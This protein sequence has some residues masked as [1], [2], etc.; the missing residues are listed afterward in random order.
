MRRIPYTLS[1]V[2]APTLN[3]P[4][5]PDDDGSA[6]PGLRDALAEYAAGR[7]SEHTVLQQLSEA[8]L[9]LPVVPLPPEQRHQAGCRSHHDHDHD[10][11]HHD[12]G[13]AMATPTLIGE[14]GRRGYLGFT[15]LE[16]LQ[17]W[18]ADARP[19][20]VRAQD[21][22]RS[23]LEHNAHALVVDVAGPVPFAV[24]GLRL[25]L[26]AEGQAIPPPHEDPEVLAAVNAAFGGEQGV[27]GVRVGRGRSAELAIRCGIAPGHDERATIQRVSDRLA[28]LLRGRIVGGVELTVSRG[29]LD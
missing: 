26:L 7:V 27:C 15:S 13:A 4:Q 20:P 2:A 8:R 23:A 24:D 5:F 21:A 11:D 17:K 14:D 1:A 29:S 3:Q 18:R 28:E 10:H 9:L 16:S 25:H 19:V 6:H 12:H 22:C